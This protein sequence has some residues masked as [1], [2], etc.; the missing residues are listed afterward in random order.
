M[1]HQDVSQINLEKRLQKYEKYINIIE[2]EKDK[3]K[4]YNLNLP[5]QNN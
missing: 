4:D 5:I 1:S 2:A 3:R